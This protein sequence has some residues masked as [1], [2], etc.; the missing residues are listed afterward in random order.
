MASKGPG[1]ADARGLTERQQKW[2]ASV[3]A[4][5]ERD[6]GKSLEEWVKIPR[7]CPEI[8]PRARARWLKDNHGLGANRAAQVLSAAFPSEAGW[9]NPEKLRETLWADPASR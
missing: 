9:D 4:S 5:L 1:A 8:R 3:A 7:T 2:F 6:P